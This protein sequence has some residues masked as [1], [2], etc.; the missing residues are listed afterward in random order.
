MEQPYLRGERF[1]S[2]ILTQY[3]WTPKELLDAFQGK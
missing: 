3:E 1:N 2:V